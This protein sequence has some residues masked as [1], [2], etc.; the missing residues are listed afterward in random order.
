VWIDRNETED[1]NLINP[2]PGNNFQYFC[3]NC[4]HPG[5]ATKTRFVNHH[6]S[7]H[8][9]LEVKL[10]PN[11][12]ESWK[13]FYCEYRT[14][15]HHLNGYKFHTRYVLHHKKN[16]GDLPMSKNPKNLRFFEKYVCQFKECEDVN[17]FDQMSL[18]GHYLNHIKCLEDIPES[19]LEKQGE[20]K[21]K[22]EQ[23][24]SFIKKIDSR[25]EDYLD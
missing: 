22:I 4:K 19:D 7:K 18:K 10:L 9:K 25:Q 14:T 6:K 5:F 13:N 16:H 3:G 15:K 20:I 24:K 8:T 17:V 11:A 12:P 21:I 2:R 23:L 1:F